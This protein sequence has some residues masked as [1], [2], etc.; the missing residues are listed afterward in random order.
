MDGE[1]DERPSMEAW[2]EQIS[3]ENLDLSL[4]GVFIPSQV[5]RLSVM[6]FG[7]YKL[8]VLQKEGFWIICM[9]I[10]IL[11]LIFES[12]MQIFFQDISLK[13]DFWIIRL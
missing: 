8:I 9:L 3:C 7:T 1:M 13:S 4:F 11:N 10:Y 6:Q 12:N 2:C 5:Q